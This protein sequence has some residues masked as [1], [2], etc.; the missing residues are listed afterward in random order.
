M[1]LAGDLGSSTGFGK[2]VL[3]HAPGRLG[4]PCTL[5]GQ[6][7]ASRLRG[8]WQDSARQAGTRSCLPLSHRAR[9]Q[10]PSG[11]GRPE[12]A[13]CGAQ[14]W[15]GSL[16]SENRRRVDGSFQKPHL[17]APPAWGASQGRKWWAPMTSQSP[18]SY[19]KPGK[20]AGRS[21]L[22]SPR[23]SQAA[24]A[25]REDW[26]V[27]QSLV[28]AESLSGREV[29]LGLPGISDPRGHFC[30]RSAGGRENEATVPWGR[31]LQPTLGGGGDIVVLLQ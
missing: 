17:P 15:L 18:P 6:D 10:Q 24:P 27:P 16:G 5:S 22:V 11:H 30:R 28:P 20:Q 31:G 29:L 9:S 25:S 3:P 21:Y 12:V 26:G 8:Q 4:P 23:C 13:G 7:G 1:V 19:R 2:P 14:G